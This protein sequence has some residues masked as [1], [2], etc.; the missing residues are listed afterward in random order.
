MFK[1]VLSVLG[2]EEVGVNRNWTLQQQEPPNDDNEPETPPPPQ[3]ANNKDDDSPVSSFRRQLAVDE[4]APGDDAK[5]GDECRSSPPSSSQLLLEDLTI[6]SL[7]GRRQATAL[8]S[9]T[10]FA[11]EEANNDDDDDD[12]EI[13]RSAR[14]NKNNSEID[15]KPTCTWEERLEQEI[16][17]AKR[18]VASSAPISNGQSRHGNRDAYRDELLQDE[19]MTSV[20]SSTS[21][22]NNNYEHLM[23]SANTDPIAKQRLLSY[24]SNQD[25]QMAH[26]RSHS[27]SQMAEQSILLG[28][29]GGRSD[30]NNNDMPDD[31][32]EFAAPHQHVF[33]QVLAT[34][35]PL[36][37]TEDETS[38]QNQ[39][40]SMNRNDLSKQPETKDDL[41]M[42]KG[43]DEHM[44]KRRQQFGHNRRNSTGSHNGKQLLRQSP[45]KWYRR[46]HQMIP[47]EDDT[48]EG[49]NIIT[50]S[51]KFSNENQDDGLSGRNK[52][53]QR[54]NSD[55]SLLEAKP[56]S[57][58]H[59]PSPFHDQG[60]PPASAIT[61][62]PLNKLHQ[63]PE[64]EIPDE[65]KDDETASSV[66]TVDRH[67]RFSEKLPN[68]HHAQPLA[69]SVAGEGDI[70]D[71]VSVTESEVASIDGL[72]SKLRKRW[73]QDESRRELLLQ[74]L[75][76]VNSVPKRHHHQQQ[77]QLQEQQSP[78]HFPHFTPRTPPPSS[79]RRSRRGEGTTTR[80]FSFNTKR[81]NVS[82]DDDGEWRFDECR[83]DDWPS[84]DGC[85]SLSF[86]GGDSP[87]KNDEREDKHMS[88][89]ETW[90]ERHDIP[91]ALL[92]CANIIHQD[93]RVPVAAPPVPTSLV[94]VATGDDRHLFYAELIEPTAV[95]PRMQDWIASQFQQRGR[96]PLDGS[97]HL[98][99]SR[100]VIVHEINRG[101]WTWCT[102]WSPDGALLAIATENHHLAIVDTTS[103]TV[104]RVRHDRRIRGPAKTNTTQSIRSISWGR[105]YIAIGG[106]GNA[107]S[108]LAQRDP[109]Q[110]LHTIT[111][112]G[113]V[114]SLSWRR[115][116][117]VLAIGSRLDFVM[118]VRIITFEEDPTSKGEKKVESEVLQRIEYKYW[119]N[120]VAFSPDGSCLAVGDSGGIVSV[121]EYE[122]TQTEIE[123]NMITWFKRKDSILSVEWSPEGKWLYAGGEDRSVGVIDTAH[124]EIVHRIGRDRWVQCIAA[125][126]GGTH[127]AIGGVS[128]EISILDV[129]KGWD[130]VM[131]IELKGLVPLS[132]KWHP[133]DQYLALTGQDNSVL[134][135]ETTNARH[136]KGH[137][138]HSIS[139]I[140]SIEFSP[141]GRM[142]VIGNKTGVVT[143]YSLSGTTFITAY[144]LVISVD[145]RL[146]MQWSMNGVFV[147][148]G[149]STSLMIIG[150]KRNKRQGKA[151]PPNASGFSVRKVIRDFGDTNAV[152]IDFRSHYVAVSGHCTRILDVRADFAEVREWGNGP[153]YA[154][155]WSPD[156]RW[157][158]MIGKQKHLTIY[159]TSEKRVDRWRPIFSLKCNFVGLALA[160][161]PLIVGGLLYLAYGGDSN[162]IYIMEIRT[163]EGTWETVLRIPR[164]DK[165]NTLDWSTEGLLAA[166]IGNGTVGIVDLAYLQ[167][168]V[169]V[170]E[171]DYNWQRQALTC[172]TEIRRNRGSNSIKSLRWLPAAPGS[173][174]LLAVGGTDGEVEII[175]LTERKRCRGY[176]RGTT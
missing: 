118:I 173:D 97:Y 7:D 70:K 130:S 38:L 166:G 83:F 22:S 58:S 65:K 155:A 1:M 34:K 84:F 101:N 165:I 51:D 9:S 170:N 159:D 49:I 141:D 96:P 111:G 156:G 113:F 138:L 144:E 102:S 85:L 39:A 126:N 57:S 16:E 41:L 122:E 71:A 167:S 147:V 29:G 63:D 133:K 132:A 110:I 31:G 120:S 87:D 11:V 137:H 94:R 131:G 73:Q 140:F 26:R 20:E 59:H 36:T 164:D 117:D 69:T 77:K 79:S 107:V 112:T 169:A 17:A 92:D 158:A 12:D 116:S 8:A 114:G 75:D 43:R 143:F 46:N 108:I 89:K 4:V 19:S 47:E 134:A 157:L 66:P 52:S 3:P 175:D 54:R 24:E 48:G 142:A 127:V 135:V 78:Q 163:H 123:T 80:L 153:Y 172:F 128:S 6:P 124:W 139:P 105:N 28:R 160:W 125:S 161:G 154:N 145:D 146:S 103:S 93:E 18:A 109:Y 10:L 42:E 100:T 60:P 150:R 136:V 176:V 149:S 119:V 106:T 35:P 53:L 91:L 95:D 151:C 99:K 90:K 121:Y 62:G 174:R 98:G 162:E 33:A 129:E 72:P 56:P 61:T 45:E 76:G 23:R 50:A 86:W 88:W 82:K 67:A 15:L 104:W 37:E 40:D 81:K 2:D 168:G 55:G 14:Q 44:A 152:S 25:I 64:R 32:S 21:Y 74:S 68:Q 171:M 30:S 148:I 5:E 115:D 13:R 27:A